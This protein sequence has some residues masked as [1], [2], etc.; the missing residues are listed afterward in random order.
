V[1]KS[2]E[3]KKFCG[4]EE[5]R[6]TVGKKP[7]FTGK[8]EG[9]N[10]M[11]KVRGGRGVLKYKSSSR[12]ETQPALETKPVLSLKRRGKKKKGTD[13]ERGDDQ[14]RPTSC[15]S[16]R[17]RE[18]DRKRREKIGTSKGEESPGKPQISKRTS[19]KGAV[20]SYKGGSKK[21]VQKKTPL[22]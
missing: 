16:S 12:K 10:L 4:G 9:P 2:V 5:V 19:S 22:P 20:P 17:A 15:P 18:L 1:R 11:R 14:R 21:G 7:G 3:K 8:G 13:A 6:G